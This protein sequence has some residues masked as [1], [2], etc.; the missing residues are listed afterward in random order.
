MALTDQE[1]KLL[2]NQRERAKQLADDHLEC[3][4]FGHQWGEV[5]PDRTPQFGELHVYQCRR[6]RMLRDDVEA[7]RWREI[8]HRSYRQPPGYRVKTPDNGERAFSAAALR[9][10]RA[11]RRANITPADLPDI[12]DFD[13]WEEEASS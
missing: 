7:P 1:R 13:A 3:R 6:C 4:L 10:E 5:K 12:V 8:L 2:K 9:A 11:R